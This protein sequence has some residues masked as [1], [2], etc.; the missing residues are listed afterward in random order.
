[1]RRDTSWSSLQLSF[2]AFALLAVML[3]LLDFC[4]VANPDNKCQAN[5]CQYF[6]LTDQSAEGCQQYRILETLANYTCVT[7]L[8]YLPVNDSTCFV[9]DDWIDEPC[10]VLNQCPRNSRLALILVNITFGAVLVLNII[11]IVFFWLTREI[12]RVNGYEQL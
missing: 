1:M 8:T 5:I 6:N 9:P 3:F 11:A 12:Q 2:L 4:L 10:P 7:C